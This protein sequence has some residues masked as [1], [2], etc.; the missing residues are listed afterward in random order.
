MR[1]IAFFT[2]LL[3][4]SLFQIATIASAQDQVGGYLA[5]PAVRLWYE[6]TGRL[7]NN[8]LETDEFYLWNTI[9]GEGSAEEQANDTL[10]TIDL[11][12]DGEQFIDQGL[13]LTA[14]NSEGAVIAQRTYDS[15]LTGTNGKMT[16]A[17]WVQNVGCAGT[18]IFK[19]TFGQATRTASL[20]FD[21]GE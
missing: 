15:V 2:G 1:S 9:I 3:T 20:D 16:A 11:R 14:I 4:A 5:N 6:E 19:A 21:C 17:L 7:S 12:S 18:V 10:F 8:I 13:T